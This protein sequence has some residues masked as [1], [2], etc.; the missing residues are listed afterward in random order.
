MAYVCYGDSRI[1]AFLC[2]EGVGTGF[3]FWKQGD[4][5]ISGREILQR[6][7]QR[8]SLFVIFLKGGSSSHNPPIGLP[9]IWLWKN[10]VT[11]SLLKPL[12]WDSH[13]WLGLLNDLEKVLEVTYSVSAMVRLLV[14]AELG[15]Q[16]TKSS[17]F[18]PDPELCFKYS[19]AGLYIPGLLR[20]S[21]VAGAHSHGKR[22]TFTFSFLLPQ[23]SLKS[24][25]LSTKRERSNVTTSW[26]CIDVCQPNL[27][28]SDVGG[29]F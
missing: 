12:R 18:F 8:C 4:F 26:K 28:S 27:M 9:F 5:H 23:G 2:C 6:E 17:W 13:H 7:E 21:T 29:S 19:F 11:Y 15:Y 14:V 25:V 22:T 16:T 24:C 20:A 10:W 1:F 3:T